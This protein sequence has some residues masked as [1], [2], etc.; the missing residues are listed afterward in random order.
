MLWIDKPIP[1]A[2]WD[3]F[4]VCFK[5]SYIPSIL[6]SFIVSK[7]QDDIWGFGV[8][9][10]NNVGVAWVKYFLD[11]NSYVS[12]AASKSFRWIPIETLINMCCGLS[13]ISPFNFNK[14]DL[15]KV[16]KPK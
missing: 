16:L 2:D 10:L 3:I 9:E 6:S 5:V 8:P 11:I 12:I 7:K 14:Y 4:A 13:A 15:S 1:P